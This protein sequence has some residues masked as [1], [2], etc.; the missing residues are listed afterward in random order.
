MILPVIY[1]KKARQK[2]QLSYSFFLF[3]LKIFFN[4]TENLKEK[5]HEPP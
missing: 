3:I 2:K 4:P 1:R 5:G